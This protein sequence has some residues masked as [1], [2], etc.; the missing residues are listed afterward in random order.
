V[1]RAVVDPGG[2]VDVA[3]VGAGP[4]GSATARRLAGAGCRVA[5][6]ERSSF[7]GPR[8][9]ESLAPSVNELL[10]DLGVWPRFA[11]LD[12]V[13][14]YG[15]C[16]VW[17]DAQPRRSSHLATPYGCGW[18]VDRAAFDRMLADAAAEAGAQLR[19][20]TACTG[21]ER[22]AEGWSLTLVEGRRTSAVDARVVVDATGR[23]ARVGRHLGA[24]RV[25][26]DRLLGLGATFAASD[27]DDQRYVLVEAAPV[28]WWYSAPAAG[29]RMVAM[30]MTD[31]DLCR[32]A[33]LGTR[34]AWHGLLSATGLTAARIGGPVVAGPGAFPS[35]GQRLQRADVDARWLG[36]GDAALAVDPISGS[37]VVR[38][39]RTAAD[40]AGCVLALLG[41]D[42]RDEPLAAYEAAR[43]R[44]CAAYLTERAAY[45]GAEQRWASE[46]F[47]RRRHVGGLAAAG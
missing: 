32:E 2:R 11:A 38:A 5:L 34:A 27:V 15:T 20:G 12:P 13:P 37:G 46:P 9:G 42:R 33:R 24:R 31:A 17:G 1:T 18:H 40:A 7:D 23:G 16:G 10:R 14:S 47:W 29:D 45:Y 26:F 22:V 41:S 43:D 4:A 21:V 35:A 19:L 6:V 8:V 44:E 30:L 39:L 36:V 25:V 28:G 3:V